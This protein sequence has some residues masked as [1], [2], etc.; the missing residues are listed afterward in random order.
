MYRAYDPGLIFSNNVFFIVFLQC[1]CIMT[2]GK[3]GGSRIRHYAT[4]VAPNYKNHILH[5]MGNYTSIYVRARPIVCHLNHWFHATW[6]TC[7]AMWNGAQVMRVVDYATLMEKSSGVWVS[8][9]DTMLC[10]WSHFTIPNPILAQISLISVH[11]LLQRSYV[12]FL[13][14]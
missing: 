7:I 3:C 14:I 11:S 2:W 5:R 1:Q 13:N 10:R 9:F 8:K 4:Y 6:L 12:K